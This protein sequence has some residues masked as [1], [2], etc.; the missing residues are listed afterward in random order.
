MKLPTLNKQKTIGAQEW[1]AI[2]SLGVKKVLAKIDT[3][4]YTGALHC[5][6]ILLVKKGGKKILRFY[7]V[8]RKHRVIETEDFEERTVVSASG[9]RTKRYIIPIELEIQGKRYET[10]IGLSDRKELKRLVLIGRR[11][12]RKHGMLVDVRRN[13]ELDDEREITIT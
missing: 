11:F 2:P 4:A 6:D 5:E 8:D 13:E 10:H 3:G 7:P 1:V 12:I 9:H